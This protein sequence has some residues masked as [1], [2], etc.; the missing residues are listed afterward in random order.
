MPNLSGHDSMVA[1]DAVLCL[2]ETTAGFNERT[3]ISYSNSL[4]QRL[5]WGILRGYKDGVHWVVWHPFAHMFIAKDY[6]NVMLLKFIPRSNSAKQQQLGAS[7]CTG[8]DNNLAASLSAEKGL[9]VP[10]ILI[11]ELN[12]GSPRLPMP[13]ARDEVTIKKIYMIAQCLIF[14]FEASLISILMLLLK[15]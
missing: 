12:S 2:A 6:R 10:T 1:V 5:L 15:W 4:D 8:G 14:L 13:C 11:L 7:N 3:I 9:L